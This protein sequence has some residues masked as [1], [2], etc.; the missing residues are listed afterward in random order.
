MTG[1]R[2]QCCGHVDRRVATKLLAVGL[3][4]PFAISGAQ[5]RAI[6]RP[7]ASEDEGFM[8]LALDEAA[9]GDF[10]FGAVIVKDGGAIAR[11]RNRGKALKDPTA[12]GEMDAIHN[13]L[14]ARPAEDLR[15]ATIYT[16]GEPCA[17]CMGAIVWCGFGRLVFAAS[18]S[19]LAAKI[20]Q[21]MVTSD[22]IAAAA[23]FAAVEITGGVMAKEALALF[24]D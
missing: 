14:A 8:R 6:Q 18:I 21:I 9:R 16:T 3:A 7:A 1:L 5:A 19:Q 24:K 10:P 20:G 4:A 23:D 11:G 12:H 13:F 2:R 17:M 15:G 22:A